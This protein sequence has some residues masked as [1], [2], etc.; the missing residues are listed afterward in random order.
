MGQRKAPP[1]AQECTVNNQHKQASLNE[2]STPGHIK[3]RRFFTRR[4]RI[5]TSHNNHNNAGYYQ[6]PKC[7]EGL[8][9]HCWFAFTYQSGQRQGLEVVEESRAIWYRQVF[10]VRL[11]EVEHLRFRGG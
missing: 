7:Q 1:I 4:Q 2:H 3:A 8:W 9:Y 10:S 6:K 5:S 11:N